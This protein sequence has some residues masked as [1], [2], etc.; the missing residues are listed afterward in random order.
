MAEADALPTAGA[1]GRMPTTRE[2]HA[3]QFENRTVM[4]TGA[5]GNLGRAVASAFGAA[6]ARLAL[7]DI[8]GDGLRHAF[9]DDTDALRLAA[10]LFDHTSVVSAVDDALHLF[11]RIDVLC[12]LAGGFAMGEAVHETSD[13]T[14]HRMLDLNAGSVVNMARAVVPAMLDAGGGRIVNVAAMG[15]LR[16]AAGLSAYAVAKSAVIRLTESMSAELRDSGINV[17][18]VMPSIIDTPENRAAMPDA[19]PA[20]WVAPAALA[21]VIMFLASDGAR[22]IHGAAIP[23]VG[24]S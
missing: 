9:G 15:G 20:R 13:R 2:R 10:D 23:V 8:D 19:D 17:N 1:L 12:N 11:G 14:W 16:G 21:D 4:I 7:V 18:C 6:G 3:M 5:A 24:L 22:A